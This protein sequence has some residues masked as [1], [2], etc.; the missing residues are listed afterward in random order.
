MQETITEE[1]KMEEDTKI[2]LI[3]WAFVVFLWILA[4]FWMMYQW[5]ECKAEGLSTG[6]CIQHIL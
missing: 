6:Y 3:L 4:T 5:G 1:G 2:K